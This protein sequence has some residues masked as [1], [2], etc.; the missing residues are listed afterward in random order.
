MTTVLVHPG[1]LFGSLQI[2]GDARGRSSSEVREDIQASDIEPCEHLFVALGELSGAFRD[3]PLHVASEEKE[4][5]YVDVPPR[6]AALR[7]FGTWVAHRHNGSGPKGGGRVLVTGAWADPQ[8]GC[9]VVV[10]DKINAEGRDVK[11]SP[12]AARG[13]GEERPS[14]MDRP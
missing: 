2:N 7:V 12:N 9:A 10:A 13:P 4:P 8:T 14:L 6:R 1:S 3:S 11:I 5:R